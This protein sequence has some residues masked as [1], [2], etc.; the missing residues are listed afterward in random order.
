MCD[1]EELDYDDFVS[2]TNAIRELSASRTA[3]QEPAPQTAG[4]VAITVSLKRK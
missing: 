2:M 3:A 1:C 4:P